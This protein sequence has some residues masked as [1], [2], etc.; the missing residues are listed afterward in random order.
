MQ[1]LVDPLYQSKTDFDIFTELSRRFGK[2]KEYTRDMD[3]MQWVQ[4]LYNDCR[5][6][7]AGKFDM[8]EFDVFWQ[9]GFLDF[10]TGKPWVRHADF[11][12]DP[13]INALGTPSG[14][15]EISSR[16][17]ARYGYEHCQGHPMWFEKTE[18]SHGGYRF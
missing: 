9:Q 12:Q 2:N 13:E 16:K 18:R 4:S 5:K 17:I 6:A 3:E 11:R 15:I 1:K 8:P 7:N 14:F 10:G